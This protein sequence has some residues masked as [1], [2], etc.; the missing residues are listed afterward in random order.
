MAGQEVPEP[1]EPLVELLQE[2]EQSEP[3]TRRVTADGDVVD[4]SAT[5]VWFDGRDWHFD[6]QPLVWRRVVR[7]EPG[8][9][10][11][12]RAAIVDSGFL[13]AAPEHRPQGTSLGGT[14]V[15]W[16]ATA[17]KRTHTVRLLGVPDAHVPEVAALKQ[18]VEGVIARAQRRSADG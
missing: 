8:D 6:P 7:L 13:D 1:G 17:G 2:R 4:R 18:A 16:T 12:V 10:E 15:T 14:N 9:V 11:A 5:N 3:Y